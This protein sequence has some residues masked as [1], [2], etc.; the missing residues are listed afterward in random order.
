ML[1]P[2]F[3]HTLPVS[4]CIPL[5]SPDFPSGKVSGIKVLKKILTDTQ[6]CD[7]LRR[8]VLGCRQAVRHKTLTLASRWFESSHSS[9]N[10]DTKKMCPPKSPILSGFFATQTAIC[11]CAKMQ[12]PNRRFPF[13]DRLRQTQNRISDTQADRNQKSVCLFYYPKIRRKQ[14]CYRKN[15]PHGSGL[16]TTPR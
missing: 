4:H 7:T 8:S 10:A 16:Y 3:Q 2:N 15:Y 1:F 11:L 5:L 6:F 9:H 12:M 14:I 13:A